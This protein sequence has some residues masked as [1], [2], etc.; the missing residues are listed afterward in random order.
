[1]KQRTIKNEVSFFGI[2]LHTA[3][4]VN[5]KLKPADENIGI[6]FKR[7]DLKKDNE[8]QAL[9]SNVS[10]TMLG[11]VIEKKS[12][13]IQTIEHLM[14]AIWGCN[15]DNIIIEIDNYEIPIMDGSALAF[16]QEI[17]KAGIQEQNVDKKYLV[18]QKEVEVID[19]KKSVKITPADDFKVNIEV[20][21]NYGGIGKQIYSFDGTQESFIKEIS[22]ARTF[23]NFTEI[24]N[25]Q[26]LGFARGGYANL[27]LNNVKKTKTNFL[28]KLFGIFTK[29][30]PQGE[31]SEA[32]RL[33]KEGKIT[34][35]AAIY[36][37][38]KIL[39]IG[40]LRCE[41]EVVKHK[42][43][44]LLGDFLTSGYYIKG[45]VN[46]VWNGHGLH[47]KFLKTLL[48]NNNNYKIE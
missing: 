13:K 26:K 43:I 45:H 5:I 16:I 21:F 35:N 33:F 36:D 47:N 42:L 4:I 20:D 7:V 37:N 38:D 9:Y 34:E 6:V 46:A 2:G 18:V 11:T 23:C 22:L 30:Q 10:S 39:N 28:V 24:K 41:D 12:A 3:V 17:Q 31:I 40:G 44:D 32:E 19:G 29:K 15:I 48:F 14:A 27:N 8:V 1:M 25:M